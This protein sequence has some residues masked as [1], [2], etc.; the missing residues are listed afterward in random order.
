LEYFDEEKSA[1]SETDIPQEKQT[2]CN[3]K[4]LYD[5]GILWQ[6][7]KQFFNVTYENRFNFTFSC[8]IAYILYL[9]FSDA[10]TFCN[11]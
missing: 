9:L 11:R 1:L 4:M 5:T 3:Y 7:I 8:K 2:D 10:F 6:A